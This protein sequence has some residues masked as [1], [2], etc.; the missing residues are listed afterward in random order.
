MISEGFSIPDMSLTDV[1]GRH[2]SLSNYAEDRPLLVVFSA[3][4]CPYVK[5][6]EHALGVLVADFGSDS[7]A[8]LAISSNDVGAYPDDDAAGLAAQAARANWTFPYLID[9]D[10]SVAHAFEAVCTPDFFLFSAGGELVYRGALDYSSPGND[11]PND[12]V[13]MREAIN[14][15]IDKQP[16]PA[17]K[18]AAM[19]CSIK[20]KAS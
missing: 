2:I 8:V 14:A 15:L 5:H 13:L 17:P 10:Q 9:A 6:L 18:K 20:W 4:H 1:T 3:N 16:V 12:G 7:L 19:G 11:K